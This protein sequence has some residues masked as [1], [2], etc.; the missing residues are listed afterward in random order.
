MILQTYKA[1]D[2][3]RV[4][5]SLFSTI[6]SF[7]ANHKTF[8]KIKIFATLCGPTIDF[9]AFADSLIEILITISS[10]KAN[11]PFPRD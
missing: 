1:D 6:F 2:R 4:L 11:N 10:V 7:D 3:Q 5:L 8:I 9:H